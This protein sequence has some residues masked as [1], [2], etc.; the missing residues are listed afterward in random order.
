M[1]KNRRLVISVSI[2]LLL[3]ASIIAAAVFRQTIVDHVI[4]WQFQPS[5]E[6]QSFANRS[7]MSK[8]GELL[9]YA[10]RPMLEDKSSFGTYCKNTESSSSVLGCYV[11]DR[12][13]LFNVTDSSLEG[14]RPVTAAHEMLH[15]AYQRLDSNEKNRVNAM[16]QSNYER[17]KDKSDLAAAMDI[18]KKT[19]PEDLDNELHSLLGTQVRDLSPDL[20][21]YYERYFTDRSKVVNEYV[22]YRSVFT[23]ISQKVSALQEQLN[24]LKARIES[25]SAHYASQA[26]TL[27]E[28][29]AAFN[30]QASNAGF[31]SQREFQ[32]RRG[33]L[34]VRSQ[35]L[36]ASR[37][38]INTDIASYNELIVQYNKSASESRQ[39]NEKLD[40]NLPTAPQV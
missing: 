13:Y 2:S 25:A 4:A 20:S 27:N 1:I 5:Q 32:A 17:L 31:S 3:I 19:E 29:I 16:V 23:A 38:T 14:I 26:N 15:A 33:T 12:I 35:Q 21:T 8:H 40:S 36:Q 24:T 22:S 34:V 30:A 6:V 39:L 37:D 11:D 28:D 18:Y 10:S 9:Y 7:G